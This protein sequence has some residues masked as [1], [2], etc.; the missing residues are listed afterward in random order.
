M[1]NRRNLLAI[2]NMDSAK[3]YGKSETFSHERDFVSIQFFTGKEY[4]N[5]FV[6]NDF[7]K[8]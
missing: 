5:I 4:F 6:F 2:D 8:R 3:V 7:R 1:F